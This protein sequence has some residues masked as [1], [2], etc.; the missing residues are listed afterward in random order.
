MNTICP[1]CLKE[2]IYEP[3]GFRYP[4]DY[5]EVCPQCKIIR[6]WTGTWYIPEELKP[7]YK[8][9]QTVLFINNRIK[10]LHLEAITKAQC[11]RNIGQYFE[12]AKRVP[13]VY[14]R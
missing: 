1:N 4:D 14:K 2:M 13:F 8:Q 3:T 11:I 10:G 9:K 6:S 7:T 12:K 5:Q